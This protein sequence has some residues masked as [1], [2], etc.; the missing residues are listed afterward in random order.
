MIHKCSSLIGIV[1]YKLICI[2]AYLRLASSVERESAM[3]SRIPDKNPIITPG[4]QEGPAMK[5]R[6]SRLPLR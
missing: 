3:S 1:K 2:H 5:Y 6:Y 4:R